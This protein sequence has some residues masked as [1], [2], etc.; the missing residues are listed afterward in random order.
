MESLFYSKFFS[1]RIIDTNIIIL[2][3]LKEIISLKT[4][5]YDPQ[6]KY[7]YYSIEWN[8]FIPWTSISFS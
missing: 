8:S 7:R 3:F 6:V 5:Y 4:I 2:F 1:Q